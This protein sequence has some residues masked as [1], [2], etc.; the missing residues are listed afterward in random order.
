MSFLHAI[1]GVAK[2]AI[3]TEQ[4]LGITHKEMK[5]KSVGFSSDVMG[6]SVSPPNERIKV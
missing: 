5:T 6:G 2:E 3:V 1:D 4:E